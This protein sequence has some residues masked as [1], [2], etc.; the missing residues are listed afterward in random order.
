[1]KFKNSFIFSL[2]IF[3]LTILTVYFIMANVF[4]VKTV[5]DRYGNTSDI[6]SLKI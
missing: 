5:N 3:A 2:L 6:S 1:M 4:N